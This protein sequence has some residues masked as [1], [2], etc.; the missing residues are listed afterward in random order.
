MSLHTNALLC[1]VLGLNLSA[2][3]HIFDCF[4]A[5]HLVR[6]NDVKFV[7]K[8]II[9]GGAVP[10][11]ALKLICALVSGSNHETSQL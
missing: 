6:A 2:E 11:R 3:V 8:S 4:V 7:R 10:E 1:S 9:V 5:L